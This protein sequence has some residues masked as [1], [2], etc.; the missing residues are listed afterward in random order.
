M[1]FKSFV[2]MIDP[3]TCVLSVEAKEDGSYGEIR[4]VDGN[5]AYIASIESPGEA[6]PQMLANKFIPDSP[7]QKFIPKDLNFEDF[8]YRSAVLKQPLHTYVHPE[9]F[10]FW[11]D[12]YFLPLLSV[13]NIHYCTYT[14]IISRNADSAQM[15]NTSASTASTVLNTC[16]KLRGTTNFRHTMNEVISDIRKICDAQSCVV[17]LTDNEKR[18][19]SVLGE[20]R[21]EYSTLPSMNHV[22]NDDFYDMTVSW[23]ETIGGSNGLIIKNA[24][25]WKYLE[26]K[27]PTWYASLK[28]ERVESL[29]LF[30]LD[31]NGE[32]LG[33]IWS[34]NFDINN[35][36]KIKETL[37]LTNYFIASEIA[38]QRLLEKLKLLSS[39]DMLTGVRNRNEMNNRIDSLR[40]DTSTEFKG[41]GIVFASVNGLKDINA[42]GGHAAGD[43]ILKNAA[44]ILQNAFFGDEI[45]RADGDEFMIFL[46]FT[47]EE[48]I[49]E[50]CKRVRMLSRSYKDVSLALGY[51]FQNDSSG[52]TAALSLATQS[53]LKDKET[54]HKE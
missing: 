10:D 2:D 14:Q 50:K 44:M 35:A 51:S 27:N 33:Y 37:E 31:V 20:S 42:A 9:R 45:Y 53:M 24:N 4:I 11:F 19:C 38:N 39:T 26:E 3:M 48:D 13:G 43:L 1:D 22:L 46:S 32:T 30:P 28:K 6:M 54:C 36:V 18:T 7:Y 25:D 15:S 8:C 49:V 5:P 12:L 34:C 21:N 23:K 17:L 40:S 29:V 41:I 47:T 52:I 16:I